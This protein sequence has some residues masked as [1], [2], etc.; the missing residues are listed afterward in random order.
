MCVIVSGCAAQLGSAKG[1]STAHDASCDAKRARATEARRMVTEKVAALAEAQ[2]V[3]AAGV[4]KG[5]K[6]HHVAKKASL[7]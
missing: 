3:T 2:A 4:I 7:F 6:N 1:H 5:A